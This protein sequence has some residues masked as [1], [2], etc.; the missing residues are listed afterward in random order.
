MLLT[1][2]IGSLIAAAIPAGI[3]LANLRLYTP[4]PP[5]SSDTLPHISILIPARNEESTIAACVQAALASTYVRAEV[6]V[7]DDSSTDRTSATVESLLG[8]T[9]TG[10]TLSLE[11]APSLPSGWNGKQHACWHLACRANGDIFLFLDADVLLAPDCAARMAA[12]LD[13]SGSALVSGFPRQ[14]TVTWL[15]QLLLPLIHFVLLGFLPLFQARD[16]TNPGYAAG[17]GQFLMV[18]REAYFK[19]GG[20][21]AICASMHDGIKLPRLLRQHGFRTD[22]ADI[23][24]LATCRM[25]TSAGQVWNGLAK[26]ATEGMASPAA[27]LPVTIFLALGQIAPFLLLR[28]ALTHRL[29]P[30]TTLCTI[31]AIVLA[32]LPRV[33]AIRRFR[34]PWISA[35]VHPLGV[36]LLLVLQWHALLRS[37]AGAQVTWK[38]RAYASGSGQ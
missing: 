32:W 19:S 23:T 10:T 38:S 9:Q 3:F 5:V 15:E 25:Y 29:A 28:L 22:L 24:L 33:L 37:L 35:L 6:V 13:R 30:L 17:C 2:A 34:Q 16:T 14:V 11:R 31:G 12:F 20:H 21:A 8:K 27:I 7:M 18:R 26:N 1:L 36:L 4:P